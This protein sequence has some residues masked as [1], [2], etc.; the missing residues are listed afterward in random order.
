MREPPGNL[1]LRPVLDMLYLL[2]RRHQV[3]VQAKSHIRK[4]PTAHTYYI[5]LGGFHGLVSQREAWFCGCN[6]PQLPWA[7][8]DLSRWN[9]AGAASTNR[10]KKSGFDKPS[11]RLKLMVGASAQESMSLPSVEASAK[12][13]RYWLFLARA[14]AFV[15][16]SKVGFGEESA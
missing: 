4:Q 13:L 3:C 8:S 5:Y 14:Q 1:P 9:M 2:Q 7:R 16:S 11:F 6:H 10:C 12:R 15:Q